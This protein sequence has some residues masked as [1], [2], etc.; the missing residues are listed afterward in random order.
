MKTSKANPARTT[1]VV[2]WIL[3]PV[4]LL[5]TFLAF[6]SN[7]GDASFALASGS[8][9]MFIAAVVV[10]IVYGSRARKLDGILAGEGLLAH[11]TYSRDE[12]QRFAETNFESEKAGKKI[13]F[14][15]TSGF[16]LIV[17]VAAFIVKPEAG[18]GVGTVMLVIILMMGGLTWFTSRYNYRQ[19]K[20]SQG[21][22]YISR[23]GVYINKQLH[24]WN[25]L[26]ARL[27][28]VQYIED[29]PPL[30]VFSYFAP[31]RMGLEEHS[32]NV[33]VPS[34]QESSAKEIVQ[35]FKS[36]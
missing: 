7:L 26:G 19:N 23:N 15:I 16:A 8:F 21:E 6:S 13:L 35:Q 36:K 20:R 4:F 1:S 27:G 25:E 12:W 33:P 24:L 14:Y 17:G 3:A 28:S 9:V 32:V 34:G 5:L 2:W 18:V 31:T 22:T 30:L 11:W 29:S 10:G